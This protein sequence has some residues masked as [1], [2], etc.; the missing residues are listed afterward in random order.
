MKKF[1]HNVRTVTQLLQRKMAIVTDSSARCSLRSCCKLRP[2][3]ADAYLT[4]GDIERVVAIRNNHVSGRP[5]NMFIDRPREGDPR[6][7]VCECEL[8]RSR[9]ASP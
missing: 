5:A 6:G 1:D 2:Y 8:S 4:F 7:R 9:E 3:Q